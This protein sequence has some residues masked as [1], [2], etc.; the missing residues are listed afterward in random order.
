MNYVAIIVGALSIMILGAIWFNPKVFGGP[1]AKGAGLSEEEANTMSPMALGG[2]LLMALILS[3]AMSQYAGHT[4]KDMSQFVHGLYHG[5]ML[6]VMFVAPVLISKSLFERKSLSWILIST[7]YWVVAITIM[8]AIV[9][10]LSPLP[11][12]A[13]AG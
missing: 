2:G 6:C 13:A 7:L 5:I 1:W 11:P 10:A 3:W 9:F 4:E 12:E 8:T